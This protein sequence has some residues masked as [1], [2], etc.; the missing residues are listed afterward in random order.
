MRVA[1]KGGQAI[2]ITEV[3]GPVRGLTWLDQNTIVFATGNATTGLQ[4]VAASGGEVTVLTRPDHER[5][6]AD[7]ILP[8]ACQPE[9]PCCS[10]LRREPAVPDR[11]RCW[12][13][14]DRRPENPRRRSRPALRRKRPPGVRGK[15]SLAGLAFRS[16]D[17]DD[18]RH[19]GAGASASRDAWGHQSGAGRSGE[20]HARIRQRKRHLRVPVWVD[21]DGRETPIKAPTAM[22]QRLWPDGRRLA[23]FDITSSGEYDIGILD[24]ERGTRDR[25]TTIGAGTANQSGRR[26][27]PALP[28]TPADS[29]VDLASSYAALTERVASSALPPAH[30][31]P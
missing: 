15:R 4:R 20:W 9:G 18:C 12:T 30:T 27:V 16:Q 5:G 6:E 1:L 22:S 8:G 2:T 3:D 26:M 31:C 13:C 14:R 29:L 17:A 28:I 10:R 7:H 23:F 24:L 11:L 25:L 21:R 19:T